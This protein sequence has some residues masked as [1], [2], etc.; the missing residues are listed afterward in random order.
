LIT[1]V[2]EEAPNCFLNK[3]PLQ[4]TIVRIENTS[5]SIANIE[6]SECDPEGLF[7]SIIII[8][9]ETCAQRKGELTMTVAYGSPS[10]SKP[11]FEVLS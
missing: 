8:E 1:I 5:S 4:I 7:S 11:Q 10:V 6:T 3:Y 9:D 2:L